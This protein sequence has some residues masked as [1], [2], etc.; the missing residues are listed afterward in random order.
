MSKNVVFMTAVKVDKFPYRS[1]P[2]KYG[3]SSWKKWCDKN[4]CKLMVLDE[5]LHPND[6]MRINFHRYYAF[7]ILE[8]N[9]IDCDKVL[10]TDADCIIHPDCPNFFEMTD[11]KYA[12]THTDGCYDWTCRSLENYSHF[13][14]NGETF[15]LDKYFNAG[16]QVVD[17]K[18]RYVF[19]NL[20][21]FYFENQEAIIYLQNN[22]SVGTD[23]PIINFLVNLDKK[24]ETKILSYQFCMIDLH[25]KELLDENMTFIKVMPGIYQFNAVPDNDRAVKTLYWMK[26]TY[27]HFYGKL[28][29]V[30][31]IKSYGRVND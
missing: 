10:L 17:K 13:M 7:D 16:F 21:K 24:I 19:D 20:I 6:V 25:R 11:G 4:N 14:F 5:L 26:K 15:T 9:G 18:Y 8:N 22:Y 28:H 30:L 1:E 23:Q 31:P 27:E 3:I 2:Y 29:N 12:V